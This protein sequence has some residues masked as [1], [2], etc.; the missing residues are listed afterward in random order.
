MTTSNATNNVTT[1]IS[2]RP[3]HIRRTYTL[4]GRNINAPPDTNAAEPR[5]IIG[6]ISVSEDVGTT[7]QTNGDRPETQEAVTTITQTID[8]YTQTTDSVA[9][10]DSAIADVNNNVVTRPDPIQ[11]Q[12]RIVLKME[13]NTVNFDIDFSAIDFQDQSVAATT[14]SHNAKSQT[15]IGGVTSVAVGDADCPN[16]TLYVRHLEEELKRTKKRNKVKLLPG[17]VHIPIYFYMH[18][19]HSFHCYFFHFFRLIDN[20]S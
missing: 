14:T 6:N 1:N 4:R 5:R 2:D 15:D 17:L 11:P 19:F 8:N 20:F 9:T 16:C 7:T 3:S 13:E 18:Y 12:D 10:Q